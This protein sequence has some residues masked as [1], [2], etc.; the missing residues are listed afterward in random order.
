[1]TLCSLQKRYR[2]EMIESFGSRADAPWSALRGGLVLGGE[3]LW[4]KTKRI[5]AGKG[6]Q[7]EIRWRRDE[8][9]RERRERLKKLLATEPDVRLAIWAR[10]RLGGERMVE[11]GRKEGYK[12]GSGVLQVVKRLEQAS[13]RDKFLGSKMSTLRSKMSRVES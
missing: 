10:V 11:V 6:G 8:G 2:L 4:E 5:V 7:E 1:M 12:N 13:R 9:N 3:G